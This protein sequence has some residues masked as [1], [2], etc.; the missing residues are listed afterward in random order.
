M[1]TWQSSAGKAALPTP[2]LGP[3][4]CSADSEETQSHPV[5][6]RCVSAFL[7]QGLHLKV[8]LLGKLGDTFPHSDSVLG[9]FQLLVFILLFP[10]SP[11]FIKWQEPFVQVS[12]KMVGTQ[13]PCVSVSPWPSAG[14][15]HF[16]VQPLSHC[17][18]VTKGLTTAF[19]RAQPPSAQLVPLPARQVSLGI[20]GIRTSHPPG[21][22][23]GVSSIPCWSGIRE[24]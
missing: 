16:L 9:T 19:T 11:G 20:T 13:T 8:F 15:Q 1:L 5:L 2:D 12:L 10:S 24:T 4:Q 6:L 14:S 3:S 17:Q 7:A 23:K 21:S 22:S 18:Y